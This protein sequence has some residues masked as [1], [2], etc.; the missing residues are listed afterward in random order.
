[1]LS[2]Y[3]FIPVLLVPAPCRPTPCTNGKV[4]DRQHAAAG[5]GRAPGG[6]PLARPPGGEVEGQKVA[7]LSSGSWALSGSV[8]VFQL[9]LP[10]ACR[11]DFTAAGVAVGWV[12]L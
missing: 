7:T 11:A 9:R 6:R 4:P 12:A 2:R 5:P 3:C 8:A 10:A 1:M